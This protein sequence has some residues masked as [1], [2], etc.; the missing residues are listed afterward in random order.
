M[1]SL[2]SG[3]KSVKDLQ[4]L[5]HLQMFMHIIIYVSYKLTT[6]C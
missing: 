1:G 3:T 6:N 4:V 5:Q 2:G